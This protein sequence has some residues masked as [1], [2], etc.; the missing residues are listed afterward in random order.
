MNEFSLK[1]LDYLIQST[2]YDPLNVHY[3]LHKANTTN[4]VSVL[5]SVLKA[6]LREHGW[7]GKDSKIPCGLV[8]CTQEDDS[9]MG[10]VNLSQSLGSYLGIP[11]GIF[12]T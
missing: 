5:V 11:T 12:F 10:M 3:E 9:K 4:R 7:Q 8:I 6:T 1:N 2:L